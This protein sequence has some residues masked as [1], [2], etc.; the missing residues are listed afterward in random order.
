MDDA[1]AA[2][3]GRDLPHDYRPMLVHYYSDDGRLVIHDED[4]ADAWVASDKK[5]RADWL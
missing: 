3:T 5:Y 1:T 2:D 4:N